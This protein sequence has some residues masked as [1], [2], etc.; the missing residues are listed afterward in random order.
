M[1]YDDTGNVTREQV[2][3]KL[4]QLF[5]EV[6]GHDGY[7]RIEVDMMSRFLILKNS[8]TANGCVCPKLAEIEVRRQ[9][10]HISCWEIP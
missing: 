1:A 7:G 3:G 8:M 5:D 4:E 9:I 6:L 10:F 2:V